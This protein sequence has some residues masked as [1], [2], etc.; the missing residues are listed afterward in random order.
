MQVLATK[1]SLL[2]PDTTSE[3]EWDAFKGFSHL[4]SWLCVP[5]VASQQVLGFLSL[6]D[7][8]GNAFSPEH[9]RL[10]KSLAIPAAVAIQNARLYERAEIYGT[11]LE[12]RL[13]DLEITKQ[14]LR[15]AEKD[16]TLSEERFTKVFRSSPIAFSI[17]TIEEGR[18]LDVNDAFE[19]RYGYSR[20]DVLDR[21]VFE[22]GIWDDPTERQRMLV[23]LREH[24]VRNRITRFRRS[25]GE[26][27]ETI[28]SAETIEL[29]GRECLLAV[30]EDVPS[31]TKAETGSARKSALAY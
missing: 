29:D 5:L 18:I 24:G 31:Q 12:H 7:T 9:M 3:A 11:E 16:R 23:E 21:T 8:R 2:V 20:Q 15:K 6:G 30:S 28:Y 1:N 19:R 17:T 26:P 14:A 10:A 25:T 4:R 13:A 27:I 22:I